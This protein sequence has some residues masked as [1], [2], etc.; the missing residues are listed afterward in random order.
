MLRMSLAG[1]PVS[2]NVHALPPT[3]GNGTLLSLG[4]RSEKVK[5]W[6]SRCQA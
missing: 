6:G 1:W 2:R 4:A 5:A 3:R